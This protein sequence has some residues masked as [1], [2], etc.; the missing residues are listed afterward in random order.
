MVVGIQRF[1]LAI[2]DREGSL[3]GCAKYEVIWRVDGL[4]PYVARTELGW[5]SFIGKEVREDAEDLAKKA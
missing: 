3:A 4:V 5:R 1:V 2:S